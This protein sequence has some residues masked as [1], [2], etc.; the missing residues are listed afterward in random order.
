MGAG[1]AV[2]LN[3]APNPSVDAA[4]SVVVTER[5]GRPT[6]YMITYGLPNID[7]DFPLLK[8]NSLGPGS[9]LSVVVQA[10]D[11]SDCLVK[12]PVTSQVV[13]FEQGG[14]ENSLTVC[15]TDSSIKM[16]REDKVVVWT[17]L[18]DSQAVSTILGQAGLTPDVESTTPGHLELKH[19]LLQRETDLSFIQRLARRNGM[20]FWITCDEFGVETGHFKRPQLDSTPKCDLIINLDNPPSN[21]SSLDLSWNIEVPTKADANELDLNNKSDI[22]GTIERSPLTTLGGKSLADIVSAPQIVHVSAPVDDNGDLSARG[23][24]AVIDSS[25]FISASGITTLSS[26]KKA[27]RSHT[28][29]NLRGIGSRHSGVWLCSAVQHTI[30]DDV[31]SMSFELIRNGWAE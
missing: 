14:G 3:N 27:L 21:I 18:T 24:A 4:S 17:D 28:L 1:F 30:K 23:E 16:N 29:V 19:T 10:E 12:G 5:L 6:E 8:D 15:G 13:H 2:R 25:F 7:Q 22:A 31:H 26:L 11:A 20:L 9:E